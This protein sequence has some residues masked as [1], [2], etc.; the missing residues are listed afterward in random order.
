MTLPDISV[1]I[2]VKNEAAGIAACLDGVLSQ[3]IPVRE[4]LVI[5]SGST[6]GTQGI[7][8]SRPRTRVL[9]IAPGEFNHGD[10]RNLGVRETKGQFILFTVGDARP[11]DNF[12]IE[13]LLAGF[14]ADDVAAVWG[15]QMVPDSP[16]TNPIEWFRQVSEP[17]LEVFRFEDAEAFVS[18][19]PALRLAACGLDDV[20]ALYR[21][22]ALE[23]IGFRRIVYGE[24]VMFA[25]DAHMAGW[26]LARNP[27]ARV[28]HFH[29]EDYATTVKKVVTI[30]SLRWTLFGVLPAAPVFQPMRVALHLLRRC[31]LAPRALIRWWSYNR[32]Q[33]R[34]VRDGLS[35]LETARRAG[36]EAMT[37]LH[38][39]YAGTPPI[40]LKSQ[41]SVAA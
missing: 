26:A 27:A 36:G 23:E 13:S 18:A 1:V 19:E 30:A 37:E 2:P 34:G 22:S 28:Y 15:A 10:T 6:D 3:S 35:Q 38:R 11:Y 17:K 16:D 5:D 12:W 4:I 40:P 9:E 39:K 24:D 14:E 33:V 21:R 41:G 31:G 29:L 25:I 20:T 7:A 8:R 32:D